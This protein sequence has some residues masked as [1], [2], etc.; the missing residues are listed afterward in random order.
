MNVQP[1]PKPQQ[2]EARPTAAHCAAG[3]CLC[4]Q[5]S[6]GANPGGAAHLVLV[7]GRCVCALGFVYFWTG[8]WRPAVQTACVCV[9]KEHTRHAD[10]LLRSI[11]WFHRAL[12]TS[13]L[14]S[15]GLMRELSFPRTPNPSFFFYSLRE[16]E[17]ALE[18]QDNLSINYKVE[19]DPP[20]HNFIASVQHD[21]WLCT[22]QDS[23]WVQT[24]FHCPGLLPLACLQTCSALHRAPD[25]LYTLKTFG[26]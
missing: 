25:I 14:Y 20:P 17:E 19:E 8:L 4:T 12:R 6:G 22:E 21:L 10:L 11:S 18:W 24:S 7:R 2:L 1:G 15:P 13:L 9:N 16:A 3:I 26:N 23:R 5:N